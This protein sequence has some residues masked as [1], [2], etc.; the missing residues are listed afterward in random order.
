V[1]QPLEGVGQGGAVGGTVGAEEHQ[2]S[3]HGGECVG[4]PVGI[5]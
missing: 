3:T 4:A 2:E 1:V 5:R